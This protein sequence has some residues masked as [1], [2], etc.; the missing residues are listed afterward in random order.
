M[1]QA[2]FDRELGFEQAT[3]GGNASH[4]STSPKST[5]HCTPWKGMLKS[6]TG[7]CNTSCCRSSQ[8]ELKQGKPLLVAG[9]SSEWPG[10]KWGQAYRPTVFPVFCAQC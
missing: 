6:R 10:H 9:L 3:G 8:F 1:S 4:S 5:E 7:E 2:S